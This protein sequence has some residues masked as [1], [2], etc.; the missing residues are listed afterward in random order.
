MQ[1]R[2]HT[3]VKG[4]VVTDF[5]AEFTYMESQV[6]E[7]Q[8]QWSVHT[9]ESYNKQ[10]GG[11]AIVLRS[12]E[13]DEIEC[14]VLLDFPTTNNK[15]EYETFVAGLDLAKAAWATSVVVYY[16]SQVVTSQV[17]DDFR[18][19]REKMKKYLEQVRKRVNELEAKFIQVPREE[20]EKANRLAKAASVEHMFITNKVLSFVE[21]LPL[22]D[23]VCVQEI[24]SKSNWIM[25]I[26]SYL[27]NST[28]P[29]SKEAARKLKVQAARFVLIKD[30]LYKR[31]FSHSFLRC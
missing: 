27:K 13:R 15:A 22:I 29:D 3:A 23:N 16:D 1:Y 6:A 19:K 17:N 21:L 24:D 30:V 7:E 11:V 4:Q 5:F 10:A 20:N 9:D 31:G 8:S 18:C 28:L 12:L 14:M 2:P 25:P 26:V